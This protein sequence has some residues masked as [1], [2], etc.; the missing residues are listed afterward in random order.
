[1]FMEMKICS[2]YISF[3]VQLRVFVGWL[4]KLNSFV[5]V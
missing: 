4:E 2:G 3:S 1:M 5:V